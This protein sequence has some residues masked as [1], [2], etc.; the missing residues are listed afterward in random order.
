MKSFSDLATH[1]EKFGSKI[2]AIEP[3]SNQTL[4]DM[5]AT[6]RHG[7]GTWELIEF[8]RGGDAGAGRQKRSEK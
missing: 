4:I 6:D 5:I 2:Y 7:L 1:A 8:E 3:G